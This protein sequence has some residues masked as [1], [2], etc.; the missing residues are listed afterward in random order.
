[1]KTVCRILTLIITISIIFNTSLIVL[2][3]DDGIVRANLATITGNDADE[4]AFL[5]I[6]FRTKYLDRWGILITR[7]P[8]SLNDHLLDTARI[9]HV[10]ALIKNK[11]YGGNV[12]PERAALLAMYHDVPEIV[13]D[14]MPTPVKYTNPAMKPLYDE[15]EEQAI[16]ELLFLLPQE[17]QEDFD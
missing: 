17:F 5:G 12:N 13:T 15:I 8:E 9:A 10:L 7:E 4:N 11:I 3:K 14:D 6:V 1:M 2:A 16:A